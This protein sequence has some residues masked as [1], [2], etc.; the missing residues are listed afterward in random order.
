M[1]KILFAA[2]AVAIGFTSCSKDS[3]STPEAAKQW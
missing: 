2:L 3:D 1:K